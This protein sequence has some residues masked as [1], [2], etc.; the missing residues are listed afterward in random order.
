MNVANLALFIEKQSEE[1]KA[2]HLKQKE[3]L[4]SLENKNQAL[5]DYAHVVSHDLKSPLRS[6][7]SL[8]DW[9]KEDYAH[10]LDNNGKQQ[11]ELIQQLVEKM[12]GLITG[13]LNYSTI[14]QTELQKYPVNTQDLVEEIIQLLYIPDHITIAIKG[15]LPIIEGDKFRL[16]QLFQNL[17]QNAIKSID[18]PQG[19]ISITAEELKDSYKFTISDNGKGIK[20]EHFLKI[21]RIFEK[22]DND[23]HSTGIGLS[24][25]KRIVDFY[26]GK[27][28]LE[29]ELSK[30]TLFYFI[31]PKS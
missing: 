25:V 1:I 31:L 22:I 23:Q 11:F 21:F 8:I 5:S 10:L 24:I 30:G 6:I 17:L 15:K 7:N 20:K 19:Y 16:Q 9:L 12:D 3:L 27:I 26:N 13:I 4:V 14:G 29:S 2:S 18:K 28:W